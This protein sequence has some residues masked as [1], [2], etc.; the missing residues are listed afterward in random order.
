MK[1]SKV[2][3]FPSYEGGWEISIC[4]AM[5]RLATKLSDIVIVV[6]EQERNFVRTEYGTSELNVF[7][8]PNVIEM[9]REH[10]S[11]EELTS[12]MKE[13][14]LENK[15][16]V[17]FVGDLK[18][19]QN[20]D[21]VEYITGILAPCFYEKRKDVV[22]L[23]IGAGERFFKYRLPNVVF[24]GFI[25][26]LTPFLDI[27]DV[28]IA[29][30]RVGAGVKTKILT[31]MIYGKPI[32]TTPVGIQG[33]VDKMD[34]VIVTNLDQFADTLLKAL[35]ALNDLKQRAKKNQSII[36][37]VYSTDALEQELEKI[38]EYATQR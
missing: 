28:C 5:E 16:I 32:V 24:T 4:E 17:T 34:S 27:S 25:K 20:R 38:L 8:V 2:F 7:V 31:Y 26:G 14:G 21:A 6:S 15:I 19:V 9:Q 13:W 3:V 18:S 23:I 35:D 36:K 30:L 22:F 33:N 37:D 29:P 11:V 10:Y 12:P 1:S